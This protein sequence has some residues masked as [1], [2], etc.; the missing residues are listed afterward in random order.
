MEEQ[1]ADGFTE[2]VKDYDSISRLDQWYTTI[3][4]R[5]K[6]QVND[7]PDLRWTLLYSSFN[8]SSFAIEYRTSANCFTGHPI[9]NYIV[10]KC[11]W[12]VGHFPFALQY[13]LFMLGN[14]IAFLFR[15]FLWYVTLYYTLLQDSALLRRLSNNFKLKTN[16]L[17]II[18][19]DAIKR[20]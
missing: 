10:V 19:I 20:S 15:I 13:G 17:D 18:L 8:L 16:K 11:M 4:L 9:C 3:L 1:N 6:K 5:I 14:G 12:F 7:N 2:A